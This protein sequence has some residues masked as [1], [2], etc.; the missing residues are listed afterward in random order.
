MSFPTLEQYQLSRSF[1]K[2]QF[3]VSLKARLADEDFFVAFYHWI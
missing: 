2:S 3:V 1:E